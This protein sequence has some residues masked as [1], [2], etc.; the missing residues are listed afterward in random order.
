ME[1]LTPQ[2]E[3][4][5][6]IVWKEG[7][8]FIKDFIQKMRKPAPPYTTIASVAKNLERKGYLTAKKY[9][10]TYEYSPAIDEGD[11]KSKFLSNIVKHYFEDSYREMVSFFVEKQKI[12]ADEL[13]G[14]IN[15][16]EKNERT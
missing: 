9:G 7:K 1:R 2:E 4:L 16:I 14:I 13:Q 8:G 12:S 15:L 10:N 5:M 11:Y 6:Q 3:E